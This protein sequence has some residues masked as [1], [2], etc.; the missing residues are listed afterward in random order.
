MNTFDWF[1][2]ILRALNGLCLTGFK[3]RT[4]SNRLQAGRDTGRNTD[5]DRL[6][7]SEGLI[8]IANEYLKAGAPIDMRDRYTVLLSAA[9]CLRSD[10]AQRIAIS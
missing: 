9:C 5:L 7:S 3:L 2:L 10:N 8:G 6:C 4:E 1:E